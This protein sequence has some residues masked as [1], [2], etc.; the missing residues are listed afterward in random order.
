MADSVEP[1]RPYLPGDEAQIL[2]LFAEVFGRPMSPEYWHWRFA[3]NPTGKPMIELVWDSD[4]LAAHYAVSPA[5][6]C[7]DGKEQMTA[8]S[9]STMTGRQYRGK[10]LFV[11][12]AATLYKRMAGEGYTHVWGFPNSTSH[13]GFVRDLGWLDIYEIPT[14]KKVLDDRPL[15]VPCPHVTEL[16]SFDAR[17]DDLWEA[18]RTQHRVI[19]KRD[20][21][22]LQWRFSKNPANEYRTLVYLSSNRLLGYLVYKQYK[23]SLDVVDILWRGEIDVALDLLMELVRRAREYNKNDV[24]MWLN[25]GSALHQELEKAGFLNTEPITFFGYK[26]LQQDSSNVTLADFRNWYVTMSD[27]D[28]Y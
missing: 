2:K 27:S 24:G 5:I 12:T 23:H 9:M 1:T 21:S 14:F 8:L 11:Q 19:A 4:V 10:G 3:S 13:R 7:V 17:F 20:C 16:D 18:A 26:P 25:V 6:L 15:P 28:I 22:R